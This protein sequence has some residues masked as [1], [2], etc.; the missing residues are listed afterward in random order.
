M[1]NWGM[2]RYVLNEKVE[3]PVSDKNDILK[4]NNQAKYPYFS[5]INWA[6]SSGKPFKPRS[7]EEYK[8]LLFNSSAV[9]DAISLVIE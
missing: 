5:D 7:Y 6:L 4:I 9:Q 1:F 2:H 8:S 3:P